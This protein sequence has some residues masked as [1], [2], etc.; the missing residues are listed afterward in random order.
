MIYS[1]NREIIGA[2]IESFIEAKE[3]N[4]EES[5]YR[6]KVIASFFK[7]GKLVQIP[8]QQKKREIVLF[9]IIKDF[10]NGVEYTEKEVNDTILKYNDDYCTIRRW[11]IEDGFMKRENDKYYV[12]KY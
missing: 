10:K 2:T 3:T 6:K 7:L 1:L 9:E 8:V 5:E 4:D 11:F 12:I